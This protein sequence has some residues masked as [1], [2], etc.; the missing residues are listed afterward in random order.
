M[1]GERSK[2]EFAATLAEFSDRVAHE[3]LQPGGNPRGRG[4]HAVEDQ[5][6]PGGPLT[7]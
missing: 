3:Q 4:L 6:K 5:P 7:S 2:E 1:T